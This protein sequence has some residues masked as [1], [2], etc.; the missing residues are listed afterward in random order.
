MS[1]FVTSVPLSQPDTDSTVKVGVPLND[2]S[3]ARAR[4][5]EN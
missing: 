3:S 5:A 1:V 2:G 4:K